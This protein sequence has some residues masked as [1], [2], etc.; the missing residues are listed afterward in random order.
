M[1][2][3]V[4]TIGCPTHLIFE[5]VALRRHQAR[6]AVGAPAGHRRM[7]CCT[8]R[9]FAAARRLSGAARAR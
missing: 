5:L 8:G 2:L 1:V 9:D 3:V 4:G 7:D 6:R